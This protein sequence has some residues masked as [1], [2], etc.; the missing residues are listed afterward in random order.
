M[1]HFSCLSFDQL[2]LNQL[3]DIMALRQEVFVVEQDCPY[4]DADGKDLTSYHLM[5][6]TGDGQLI[7]YAR[8][9]P[10]GISYPTYVSLGRIVSAHTHRR[11]GIGK[12]LMK[13][14][15]EYTEQLFPGEPI[16]ISAQTYLIRFYENFGFQTV[17]ETY[18]EDDIPHIAMV[19]KGELTI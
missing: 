8:I 2:S 13:A 6:T 17:G 3:Y 18:L 14:C 16:K 15:L 9:I 19:K 4:L 5:G 10:Q 7:A 11:K 1:I 12:R